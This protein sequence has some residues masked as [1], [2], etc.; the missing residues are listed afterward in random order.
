MQILLLDE[1]TVDMDVVGRLD[2]LAFFREVRIS[3]LVPSIVLI[4][5]WD[6]FV[7]GNYWAG[8]YSKKE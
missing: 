4:Q 5:L 8:M 7:S 2:L 6:W 1:I 3:N